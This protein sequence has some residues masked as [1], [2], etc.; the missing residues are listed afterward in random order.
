MPARDWERH[1]ALVVRVLAVLAVLV[2][3]YGAARGYPLSH[4]VGHA[5]PLL[6]LALVAAWRAAGRSWRGAAAAAGLMTASALV[7]HSSHGATEAHFMFFAL[8]PLAAVYGSWTPFLVAIG[9][10][11]VHHFVLG[12][13]LPTSVFDNPGPPLAMAVLHAGFV[14]VESLVCLTVRRAIDD[15]RE[16]VERLVEQRTAELRQQRNDLARLAAVVES[17]DDAVITITPDGRIVTWNPGAERLFG[18]APAEAMGEPVTIVTAPEGEDVFAFTR[19]AL[20]HRSSV[21]VES[22]DVR[23]DGSRFEALATVSNIYDDAGEVSGIVWITRDITERKQRE[24]EARATARKLED[25]AGQLTRLALHDPLTG[26]ANRAL[27]GDRL[28]QALARREDRR[29]AVL[30]L[31][32]DNFKSIN[33]VAGH[34]AGDE[35]L[36]EVARRLRSCVRPGDTVARLGGD[37]FVVLLDEVDGP[38]DG[39]AVAARIQ[40]MLET[41][42]DVRGEPFD[43]AASIGIAVSHVGDGRGASELLRDAD[44]AMY[45]AKR[46][47]KGHFELFR[48]D[49][50]DQLVAQTSLI[51]DLRHAVAEEE[52]RLLYQP[53]VDLSTGR[54]TGVEALVRWEHPEQ[55]LIP[56]DRFIPVAESTGIIVAIDD[57]VLREACRRLAGWDRAGLPALTMAI[58]VS[59]RRL[60]TGDLAGTIARVAEET[61]VDPRRLE[62]EITETVAIEHEPDA[63]EAIVRVRALGVRVAIDDFGMGHSALSRLQTFPVDRLKIDRS[64]VAALVH[65]GERGS[66]VDAMIAMGRSLGLDVV[67]EGVETEEHLQALRSLGCQSGQGYLFSKPVSELDIERLARAGA[68]L[69]PVEG[70]Q[71]A[72][73]REREVRTLLAELARVT[74]LETTYLT[75]IDRSQALQRITHARN[76]GSIDIPEGLAVDWADTLCRR[77][78]EQGVPYTDDVPGTFPDSRAA[79]DLG[80]QTYI[81]VPLRSADGDV[82]GT[83]CG[84]S[85]RR[86]PLG[87]DAVRLMAD[88]ADIIGGRF[89]AGS[90]RLELAGP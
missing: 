3:L 49:M 44:T 34:A 20:A 52:F 43:A 8:L 61:A 21:V 90:E 28:E 10:V 54:M 84:A 69:A 62:V 71:P 65:G 42:V 30:L 7:V 48:T 36:V 83:L 9:F 74:G 23:K 33:D 64:F 87:Q 50:H 86:V 63:V 46:S 77:A 39:A 13:V 41:P 82:E 78:L 89:A 60:V 35:V 6:L 4:A 88:F 22:L 19:D 66:L 18:Y 14:L 85:S 1:H 56:P 70:L 11:T 55:G 32:L 25:Q 40:S 2:P 31:D 37:E 51:R 12:T 57:W 58:N 53:Q 45:A 16:R 72:G 17:T 79:A 68:P 67:A 26:L 24:A 81:S 29:T 75:H 80:L 38:D 73:P 59:A 5:A 47:G 15:R 27:V 76:S